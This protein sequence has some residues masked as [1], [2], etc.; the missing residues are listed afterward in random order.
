M[1]QKHGAMANETEAAQT[2][3][4]ACCGNQGP[5]SWTDW[6][7]EAYCV[8]CGVSHRLYSIGDLPI[9]CNINPEFLPVCKEYYQETG[10]PC[11]TGTFLGYRD[12]PEVLEAHNAFCDWMHEKHPELYEDDQ[13]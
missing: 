6:T 9:G 4:C 1:A 3:T 8:R 10:K 11:G 12:Y 5:W 7:G 2:L 13:P